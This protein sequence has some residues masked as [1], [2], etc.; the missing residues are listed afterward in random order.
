MFF[1]SLWSSWSIKPLHHKASVP[2][3]GGDLPWGI[4]DPNKGVRREV[5]PSPGKAQ[6]KTTPFTLA[7]VRCFPNF[8]GHLNSSSSWT[9]WIYEV[10]D[11]MLGA[12]T[13]WVRAPPCLSRA[14]QYLPS[15]LP[16]PRY[17]FPPTQVF[18]QH[19]SFPWIKGEASMVGCGG[20]VNILGVGGSFKALK[21]AP[22][23]EQLN[24]LA[25]TYS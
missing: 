20:R 13:H 6:S 7:S 18:T 17:W 10:T 15:P 3:S 16:L 23:R 11:L 25:W 5:P 12:G 4:W 1:F 8:F 21:I 2:Q 19:A 14:L 22:C 24:Q 9:Y